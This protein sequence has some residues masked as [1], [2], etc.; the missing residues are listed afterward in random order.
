MDGGSGLPIDVIW[1]SGGNCGAT[2]RIQNDTN[3]HTTW[4]RYGRLGIDSFG[5]NSAGH[6]S[7]YYIGVARQTS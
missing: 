7:K 4:Q 2:V 6:W 3:D 5:I 1:V